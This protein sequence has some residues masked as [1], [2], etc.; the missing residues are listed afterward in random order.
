MGLAHRQIIVF[1]LLKHSALAILFFLFAFKA[2]AQS[3][4]VSEDILIQAMTSTEV[5]LNVSGLD[6]DDLAAAQELC[7]V[8][9][10]FDH[11]RIENIRMT[12]VSPSGQELTLVGPGRISSDISAFVNWNVL[13]NRCSDNNAPDNNIPGQWDNNSNWAAFTNYMGTYDPF[14]GCLEDFNMGSANGSWTLHIENLGDVTG[15]LQLMELIFCDPEG[16]VCEPC[17]SAAGQFDFPSPGGIVS[18]CQG[19]F[20]PQD[21]LAVDIAPV[22][23]PGQETGYIYRQ[24]DEILFLDANSNN[25]EE[26]AP[27][28]YQIC[29]ISYALSQ[30]QDIEM[31]VSYSQLLEAVDENLICA[32]LS[33]DC[34]TLNILEIGEEITVDTVFCEGDTIRFLDRFIFED[35]DTTLYSQDLLNNLCDTVFNYS[36]RVQRVDAAIT[37]NNDVVQ[38]GSNIFLNGSQSNVRFGGI[39]NYQWQTDDGSLLNDFGPVAELDSAGEYE[40]IVSS[41][42]CRDT[43]LIEI[44]ASDTFD[45]DFEVQSPVCQGDSFL[46]VLTEVPANAEINFSEAASFE[47][48]SDFEFFSFDEGV[49][50]MTAT[51]GSCTETRGFELLD[52]SEELTLS[53][54]TS[55]INCIDTFSTVTLQSN[56]EITAV[57]VTGSLTAQFSDSIFQLAEPGLYDITVETSEG[58]FISQDFEIMAMIEAPQFTVDDIMIDCDQTVP[59]FEPIITSSF[60]SVQWLGPDE[61]K[62]DDPSLVPPVPGNYQLTVYGSNGCINSGQATFIVNNIPPVLSIVGEPLDCVNAVTELCVDSEEALDEISWLYPDGQIATEQCINTG[63]VGEYMISVSSGLCEGSLSYELEDLSMD[64]DFQFILTDSVLSCNRE[65]I[66]AQLNFDTNQTGLEVVWLFEGMPISEETSLEITQPGNYSLILE[67]PLNGCIEEINFTIYESSNSL[68]GIEYELIQAVC[69][70]ETSAIRFTS[71]PTGVSFGIFIND[72]IIDF[73]DL[74]LISLDAGLKELEIIDENGCKLI[75]SFIVE[76][77]RSV[78][79][80]LGDDLEVFPGLPVQIFAESNLSLSQIDQF[81]WE[82]RDSLTCS[83]CLDPVYYPSGNESISL[84]ITDELGCKAADTINIRITENNIYYIPNIFSPNNDGNN[85]NFEIYLSDAINKVF[86]FRI[87]DRWGNLLLFVPEISGDNSNFVWNGDLDGKAAEIGVYIYMA[88]LLLVDGSER[89]IY[90]EVSLLR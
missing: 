49:F 90:G 3:C 15:M 80:D 54:E 34:I 43:A 59:A 89:Q 32:D 72:R 62:S 82:V 58:C 85:D 22:L 41:G 79:L 5:V 63:T 24:D 81:N 35:F 18:A 2:N 21:L 27:G 12:L 86:E 42:A 61:F 83:N 37:T 30:L 64:I 31:M 7:G 38:C 20:L 23:Y 44:T 36:A 45:F 11:D 39:D 48:N 60:D 14:N 16:A 9:L 47:P 65:M 10:V 52:T 66:S 76:E 87:F 56:A 88:K 6:N 46:I 33:D 74:P 78:E 70:P 84:E 71:L 77:P 19:E 26:L 29:A 50:E 73:R 75:D 4:L 17:L 8:R 40:L 25:T 1:N 67:N 68:S 69:V 53:V 51:L 57:R 55:V 28:V 13:F